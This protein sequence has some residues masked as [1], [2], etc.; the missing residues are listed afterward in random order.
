MEEQVLRNGET[1]LVPTGEI[2]LVNPDTPGVEHEPWPGA[3]IEI[4]ADELPK[5]TKLAQRYAQSAAAEGWMTLVNSC[6]VVRPAGPNQGTFESTV[7]GTPHVFYHV[8]EIHIDT[9]N[10]GLVKY[11]VVRQPDKYLADSDDDAAPVTP[12]DYAAG[13]TRVDWHYVLELIDNA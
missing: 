13:N 5:T 8:D 10:H 7:N 11:R 9:V 1:V 4:V 12:E 6:P 3:G 2:K